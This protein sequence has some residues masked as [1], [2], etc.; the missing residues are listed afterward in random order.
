MREMRERNEGEER[1][2]NVAKERN[3]RERRVREWREGERISD[4]N[5]K[6]QRAR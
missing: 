1:E 2:M 5:R 3:D 6:K 4:N